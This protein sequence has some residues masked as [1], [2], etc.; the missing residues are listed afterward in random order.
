MAANEH[1]DMATSGADR[2]AERLAAVPGIRRAPTPKLQQFMLSGFLDAETCTALIAQIDRDVR[3]STIADPNGDD[4]FRTSTTCDL[5]H[6]DPIVI[7]VNNRLH[8]LTGIPREYGEP[9]QGQRYDVGQEFKAHTDYFD[10]HGSDW[11]TYCAIPGQR[12]WTLM[13]YLNEPGAGGATRFLATGK[14][15]QPEAGKLLAWNNV[16]LDGT[17]NPDTLHHGMKVRK[18]RKYIITKW[19]RERPWPW[20]EGELA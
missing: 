19:F 14:M 8:D 6:R 1:V 13:I 15:H 7:A 11:E 5:D 16:H 20:A 4:A 3:P 9:M 10:P 2:T 12:S 17:A 18:G